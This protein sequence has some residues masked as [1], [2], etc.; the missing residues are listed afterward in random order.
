LSQHFLLS[1]QAKTLSLARV[2][3][4]SDLEAETVF[5]KVRWSDADGA[6]VCPKCGTLDA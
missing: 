5:R 2:Y 4:K 6:A 3:H 1:R